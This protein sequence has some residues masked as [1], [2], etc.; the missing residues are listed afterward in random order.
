ML[1]FAAQRLR[2][3]SDDFIQLQVGGRVYDL[4]AD[5]Q[6]GDYTALEA[7][8]QHQYLEQLIGSDK[9]YKGRVKLIDVADMHPEL[10]T[11]ITSD[12]IESLFTQELAALLQKPD[13]TSTDIA[14][15]F[16][17]ISEQYPSVKKMF[18]NPVPG[19]VKN[20]PAKNDDEINGYYTI[21]ELATRIHDL[22]HGITLQ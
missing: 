9:T 17:T 20:R 1:R 7:E 21:I 16:Y 5:P 22:L 10:F 11:K 13:M 4:F 2:K 14:S 19:H 8:E 3:N 12:G 15:Y 6:E 18:I